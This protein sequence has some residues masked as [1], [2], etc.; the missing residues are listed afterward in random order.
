MSKYTKEDIIKIAEENKVNFI[1]LQFTDI[2]GMP[3][4]VSVTTS[5]LKK[6]L[7]NKCMFDGSSIDGFV[8]IEESDMRLY[9]DL[10]SFVILPWDEHS[11]K[12]ARLICDVYNSDG[13]PFEGDPRYVLKR[14][15]KKAAD[16][17]YT[18]N[19]G[20]ECEFFLFHLDSCG[21]A[22]TNT[23]DMGGYFDLGPVDKGEGCRREIC[24]ALEKMGFEIEA[25]HHENAV[26]QHEIDF[27]YDEVLTTAD[28]VMTFK[29][30]VKTYANMNNLYATFMPKPVFG[31]C[32]SGM[33]INL[34]LFKDGNNI[35]CD[36][37][38]SR[39]L[40][41]TAYSFIAGVMHH[42]RAITLLTNPLVNSYK[43]L[44]PGYEA[45]VYIAWSAKNRSPLVRIPTARGSGTR[46]ELRNPDPAANPYLAFAAVLQAG[47]DGIEKGMTPPAPEDSN[48]FE[49]TTQERKEADIHSLPKTL[50]EAIKEFKNSEFAKMAVGEH[51]FSKYIEAK[52]KE[53]REYST[54]VSQ[55]EIDKYLGKY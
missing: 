20:P 17:G 46:I 40:S 36:E 1:N 28:N 29:Q 3:K 43:R 48:I 45:P 14:A 55:W 37:N 50:N 6:A 27:K 30:V 21:K 23:Y 39:G 53:W 12:T 15:I 2:L 9:P 10:T 24:L 38:D 19:V 26:A 11:G 31:I 7:N 32:G 5:Q 35:F 8:R 51:V 18:C 42:I 54:R 52:Q 4:S 25:S 44:V 33:H 49:L 41:K 13:T 47:L 16:M 22:T 34:S